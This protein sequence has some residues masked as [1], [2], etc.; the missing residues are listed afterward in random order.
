MKQPHVVV[1]TSWDDG[2][3]LDVR[4]ADLLR[5]YQLPGTFYVS[6]QDREFPPEQLLTAAEVREIGRDFEIGA[7]TMTHPRL[8]QVPDA[9]ARQEIVDSKHY[10]ER[11][12]KKAVKSFCYPGGNYE[13]RHVDMVREAGFSYARTVRRHSYDLKGSLLEGNTT[14]N[15]YNH[16]QDLWKIAKF[17]KFNPLKTLHY[18]QWDNLAKAMFDKVCAEGGIYHLWG[19]SWEIDAHKDWDKLEDVLRYISKR[20]GVQYVTNAELPTE[21]PKRLLIA[22][23]YFPPHL[24][25]VEFYIY[26]IGRFLE[27]EHSWQVRVVASGERGWKLQKKD[28]GGLTVYYMPYWFKLSN[29][30]LNPWWPVW[31]W[32]IMKTEDPYVLNIHA[33]VPGLPDMAAAVARWRQV[34]TVVTYHMTSMAKGKA[35]LDF[36]IKLYETKVLPKLLQPAK[37]LICGSS[38][39]REEFLRRYRD[40]ATV[41]T[42]AVDAETFRPAPRLASNSLI[43]VG[44]MTKADT[45]KGVAYLLEAMEAVVKAIPDV[46][47]WCV[48]A[49]NAISGFEAD[50]KARGLTKHVTFTGGVTGEPLQQLYRESTVFVLPTLNDSF[51]LV[52]L[53]GMASG[54]PVVSTPVGGIPQMVEDGRTGY[55]VPPADSAAL[56]EKLIYLL[57]HPAEARRLG[58]AGRQ[59]VVKTWTWQLQAAKTDAILLAA[60]RDVPPE[61]RL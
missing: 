18:F 58:K 15:A 43:M 55:L 40:K 61:D 44:S 54:L 38:R 39:V 35:G 52:V 60:L 21:Q 20:R 48:G 22:A 28:Y 46:K 10:L 14:V 27:R 56:S 24:G 36:I 41:V 5:K 12:L 1:T 6:P 17:A 25:G 33:P 45:H 9:V 13:A 8:H 47:L 51:P 42:P 59:K 11:L 3:K 26:H 49:G 23:P 53:E 7:H 19:H 50:V 16:Y 32:R 57:Q 2:H 34:P 30:P 37:G 31:L 29:S 4:L